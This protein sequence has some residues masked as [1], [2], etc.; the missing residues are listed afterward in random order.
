MVTKFRKACFAITSKKYLPTSMVI[1][2][3]NTVAMASLG[4]RMQF[5]LVPVAKSGFLFGPEMDDFF[6]FY[7][8]GGWDSME[9]ELQAI[10]S[11]L[12][13]CPHRY[14]PGGK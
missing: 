9:T 12:L 13:W 6:G 5:I 14:S 11:S 3:I 4:Y 10:E 1:H 7:P 8:V 2:L